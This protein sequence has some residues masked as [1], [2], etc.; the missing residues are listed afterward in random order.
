MNKRVDCVDDW[1]SIFSDYIVA[2]CEQQNDASHDLGHFRRVYHVAKAI[3]CYE[4]QPSDLFIILAAAYFHDIVSLPKSHPDNKMSSRYAA[5]KAKEILNQMNFPDEK[6]A[7]V[8]HA[9]AAHSFSAKIPPETLEAKIIQDADRME[10]LGALGA[11][12]TF[13]VTGRMG[14]KLFDSEDLRAERRPLDDKMFGL[15]HFFVK[16]FKLPRLLQTQGGKSLADERVRFLK[17]FVDELEIDVRQGSGG[18]LLVAKCCYDAGAQHL[19][20]FD[21]LDPMAQNRSLDPDHFAMDQ[22]LASRK[23]FP[24]FITNFLSVFER[25]IVLASRSDVSSP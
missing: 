17:Y 10:A 15:D 21:L 24:L 20:L 1:E 7:P 6:I 2:H 23:Q 5:V 4:A 9:I 8:C 19:P 14:R 13:Y 12:R 18:A 25:E 11:I 16:L 3:A 22:I